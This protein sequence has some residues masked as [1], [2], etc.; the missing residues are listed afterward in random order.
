MCRH[1]Y[2]ILITYVVPWYHIGNQCYVQHQR[3][4]HAATNVRCEII[5]VH[6]PKVCN[7]FLLTNIACNQDT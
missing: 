2:V 4:C 6:H 3:S 5:P 7:I 1:V